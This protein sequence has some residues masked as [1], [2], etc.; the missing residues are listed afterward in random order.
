[1]LEVCHSYWVHYTEDL[2][3]YASSTRRSDGV[4]II[5]IDGIRLGSL[6]LA[7][8]FV[9]VR[10]RS[11]ISKI[12]GA[13]MFGLR[14]IVMLSLPFSLLEPGV[15]CSGKGAEFWRKFLYGVILSETAS[16]IEC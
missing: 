8:R 5:A 13:L 3:R 12:S 15:E 1:M 11:S 7:K 2:L 16:W 6:L 10:G 9:G 14:C 4:A